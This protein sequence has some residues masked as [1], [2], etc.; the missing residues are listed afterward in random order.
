MSAYMVYSL[1]AEM[2]ILKVSTW[3]KLCLQSCRAGTQC[4]GTFPKCALVVTGNAS[5]KLLGTRNQLSGLQGCSRCSHSLLHTFS[6]YSLQI[7]IPVGRIELKTGL[8]KKKA[9]QTWY[10]IVLEGHQAVNR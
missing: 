3:C 4:L 1:P 8:H 9:A 2:Q 10:I 7:F 5:N 6:I